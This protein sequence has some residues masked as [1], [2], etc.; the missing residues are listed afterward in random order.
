MSNSALGSRKAT[1]AG[2]WKSR[3]T[4][5]SLATAHAT[6]RHAFSDFSVHTSFN[7]LFYAEPRLF[8]VFFLSFDLPSSVVPFQSVSFL[9]P[10][11]GRASSVCFFLAIIYIAEVSFAL[12]IVI[13]NYP[14][15]LVPTSY[16]SRSL[17]YVVYMFLAPLHLS[18]SSR[19]SA[20]PFLRYRI[21]P[22]CTPAAASLVLALNVLSCSTLQ[23]DWAEC[24]GSSD[25]HI[26]SS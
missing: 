18:L 8:V 25:V 1:S 5:K 22:I 7:M 9:A 13:P 4:A 21:L 6:T 11:K 12:P 19:A 17:V 10:S 23:Q 15:Y 16:D 26:A 24:R 20:F 2:A 14:I 3:D